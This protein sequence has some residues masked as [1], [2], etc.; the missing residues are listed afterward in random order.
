MVHGSFEKPTVWGGQIGL[1]VD[2]RNDR[3]VTKYTCL[4]S[5]LAK[6]QPSSAVLYFGN[7]C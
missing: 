6:T 7:A 4:H 1:V 3:V 2:L 5:Y